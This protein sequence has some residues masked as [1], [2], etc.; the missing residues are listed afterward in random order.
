MQVD[1]APLADDK[2]I[3]RDG[4]GLKATVVA[5]IVLAVLSLMLFVPLVARPLDG[6][7]ALYAYI[8]DRLLKGDALYRDV[9]DVKPPGFPL[10]YSL[11]FALFGR[12]YWAPAA[13]DLTLCWAT[14][15]GLFVLAGRFGGR[16]ASWTSA[17]FCLVAYWGVSASGMGLQ[18]EGFA[19][20]FLVWSFVCRTVPNAGR[21]FGFVSGALLCVAA[22]V[23]TPLALFA[24]PWAMAGPAG[25]ALVAPAFGAATIGALALVY[26]KSHS[27]LSEAVYTLT[28]FAGRFV[29]QRS[30]PPFDPVAA[31][32]TM[33][34]GVWGVILA[35]WAGVFAAVADKAQRPIAWAAATGLVLTAWQGAFWSYHWYVVN[36]FAAVGFGLLTERLAERTKKPVW[37]FGLVF[38][39]ATL[40]LS[41]DRFLKPG[42]APLAEPSLVGHW[43]R[44]LTLVRTKDF[45]AFASN[46]ATVY[47][48]PP[49]TE[50]DLY[51]LAKDIAAK[52]TPEDTVWSCLLY[53]SRCV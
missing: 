18:A 45:D 26:L 12:H 8:G 25:A 15:I 24:V 23:K 36:L 33:A 42:E 3:Q 40:I 4:H 28:D 16:A 48:D 17:L 47:G 11:S 30:K 14:A 46:F 1:D 49:V 20:P 29:A 41:P 51:S 43:S 13:L 50:R 32:S 21:A 2:A 7:P 39:G 44:F 52:T 37:A 53:T 6:D 35:N 27:A 10:L 22:T 9:W 34:G 38:V 31:V 19:A 5:A